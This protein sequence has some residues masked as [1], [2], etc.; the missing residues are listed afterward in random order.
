MPKSTYCEK[1]CF[2]NISRTSAPS[3][4]QPPVEVLTGPDEDLQFKVQFDAIKGRNLP[5]VGFTSMKWS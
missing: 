2:K 5:S 1:K 3:F 4:Q